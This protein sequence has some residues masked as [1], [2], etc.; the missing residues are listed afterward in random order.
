M[1]KLLLFLGVMIFALSSCKKEDGNTYKVSKVAI[2]LVY[3]EDSGFGPAEGVEVKLKNSSSGTEFKSATSAQ[4]IAGFEVP[5]G[6][7]EASASDSR[8]N[9]VQYLF[10]GINSKVTVDK[11]NVE[12]EIKLEM[13]NGGSVIIKE[14]YVGGCPKDDGSGTFA[15]DQYVTLYNNSSATIDISDYVLAMVNP[16]NPHSANNDY[17]E[18]GEL[19]YASEGWIPAGTALW[20]FDKKVQ[21]EAG[22]QIVIALNGAIDHTKT[23]SRSVNLSNGDYYCLY[24]IEDFNNARYYPSP[25][26]AIPTDHY[27]KAYKYG[28]GNAWP[29]SQFGPAFFVFRPKDTTLKDFVDDASTTDLYAGNASQVR[30]KVPVDWV[31]DGIEVFVKGAG[32]NQ[33]RLLPAVDAGYVDFTRAQG[34][35]LYRNVDKDATEAIEGNEGKIVYS[36]S[37]G[38]EGSTDASGIDAEASIKNGARIVYKDTNN[39]SDDFHMRSKSSLKN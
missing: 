25:S 35:T 13:S 12:A 7:Y 36:Y 9:D 3:P 34:Y 33:K 17:N 37:L 39:S 4:G 2:K 20:Y 5:Q 27:L 8:V 18:N 23:Y 30:K 19:F 1:R 26:D 15:M 38:V 11:E 24:D 28:V 22:K 21:L 29:V 32:T 14:L 31:I 10:N 6:I 16:Y